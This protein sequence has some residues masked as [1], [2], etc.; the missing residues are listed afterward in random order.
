M[1][2]LDP[3][4]L[5]ASQPWVTQEGTSYYMG[6]TYR[7]TGQTFRNMDQPGNRFPVVYTDTQGRNQIIS[8]HH[9]ATADLLNGR[10]LRA[11]HIEE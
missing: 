8:G 5:H 2:D 1:R 4:N 3:R 11:I 6:D 9:R 10:Q 7:K